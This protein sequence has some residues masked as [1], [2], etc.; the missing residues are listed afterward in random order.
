MGIDKPDRSNR[1]VDY[2]SVFKRPGKP[3][4]IEVPK[5]GH[6]LDQTR[7]FYHLEV[8][9]VLDPTDAVKRAK[10]QLPGW[11]TGD[12]TFNGEFDDAAKIRM[13]LGGRLLLAQINY[14]LKPVPGN[15][16]ELGPFTNPLVTTL[17]FPEHK[18]TYV[19]NDSEVLNY[20]AGEHLSA[21][22][23][24][25]NLDNLDL[26]E[27]E[28]T[29]DYAIASQIFNYIDYRKLL[30]EI[31]RLLKPRGR[32]FVNNVVDYGIPDFFAR[33]G[34]RPSS[35]D[36]TLSEIESADFRIIDFLKYPPLDI[37]KGHQPDDRLLCV[38]ENLKKP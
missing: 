31:R 14:Y 3:W 33:R 20:L 36:E 22:F 9:D 4:V 16:L 24:N 27:G 26:I 21:G 17:K 8:K 25:C 38:A 35:I 12:R 6:G 32:L 1:T 18:I 23:I 34:V 11:E 37:A 29:Y 2:T 28:N 13:I 30:R 15:V 7:F 10:F 5:Y 19:D